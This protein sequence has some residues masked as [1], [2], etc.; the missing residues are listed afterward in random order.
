MTQSNS[1]LLYS[2]EFISFNLFKK[3][4][5]IIIMSKYCEDEAYLAYLAQKKKKDQEPDNNDN[6]DN[7]NILNTS[8]LDNMMTK[9]ENIESMLNDIY[10]H[11]GI[12]Q[13]R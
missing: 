10:T 12:N 9:I 2:R 7:D 1:I 6:N 5:H 13:S 3:S 8:K 11:L 4:H